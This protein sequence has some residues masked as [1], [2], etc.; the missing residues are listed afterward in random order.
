[1]TKSGECGRMPTVEWN[2]RTWGEEHG[3]ERDGDE[4]SGMADH[5]GQPYAEW[6]QSIADTFMATMPD[7]ARALEI[8][9]GYGR[10]TGFLVDRASSVAL[11]DLNQN[12][13]DVCRER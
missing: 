13:L 2:K 4:W 8:A 1:M 3:W 10:W 6:K 7:G 12:C 5:C 11:V 9:P